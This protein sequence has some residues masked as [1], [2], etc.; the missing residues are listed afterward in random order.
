M[1]HDRIAGADPPFAGA[2]VRAVGQ[3]RVRSR[4]AP[5]EP[6]GSQQRVAL[7]V[8]IGL[9]RARGKRGRDLSPRGARHDARPAGPK[10]A[11][12]WTLARQPKT[13][14]L[15]AREQEAA[16]ALIGIDQGGGE[17]ERAD[18]GGNGRRVAIGA[19]V[20]AGARAW[21]R[22][23]IDLPRGHAGADKSGSSGPA[24]ASIRDG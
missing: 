4:H 22:A 11:R 18:Q 16:E 17:I 24:S 23:R 14:Q 12:R 10:R 20:R 2:R 21:G 5:G 9:E 7:T 8:G 3:R 13:G 1:H 15:T 19:R 6:A